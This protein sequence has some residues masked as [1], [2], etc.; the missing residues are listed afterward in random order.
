MRRF[1]R[2]HTGDNLAACFLEIIDPYS[3]IDKIECF[4]LNNATNNDTALQHIAQY[5]KELDISFDPLQ[6]RLHCFG[7]IINLVVKAFLW[8]SDTEVFE[9]Q[10]STYH[11]LQR[12]T[13][14]LEAWRRKGPLGKLHNI[15]TW[16]SRSPQRR[17]RFQAEVKKSLGPNT[18]AVS[19]IRGNTTRWGSDYDSLIHAFEL[20][21]PLEEF[22]SRV[23]RQ[24]EDQE[25]DGTP[26]SLYLDELT[27]ANWITLQE[28]MHILQPFRKWQLILQNKVHFRQLHDIFPAMDELLY[29]LEQSREHEIQHIPTSVDLAWNLLNKYHRLFPPT[30]SPLI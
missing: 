6:R 9:A 4:T 24:N 30:F 11:D 22:V 16:I 18:K 21:Y 13:E 20:R 1:Y 15:I 10:I 19:L 2:R 28:I 29:Q 17:E 26:A 8:G 12:E 14:E 23:L 27:P 3:I 5:L 7:H 25:N